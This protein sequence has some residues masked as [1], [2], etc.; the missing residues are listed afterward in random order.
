MAFTP[1]VVRND[2][3]A[4][5]TPVVP[6]PTAMPPR[7]PLA[8]PAPDAPQAKTYEPT[9]AFFVS[10]NT[11]AAAPSSSPPP[12]PSSTD[13]NEPKL[14]MTQLAL[15]VAELTAFPDRSAA[16][17]SE[18]GLDATQWEREWAAWQ[19]RFAEQPE[20]RARYEPL[21]QYYTALR[22]PGGP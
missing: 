22:K 12:L 13:A 5:P 20:E 7:A 16:T 6:A 9:V 17:L 15:L 2:P 11:G 3:P 18:S 8:Q 14:A 21:V 4:P 1:P 10:P 19:Q